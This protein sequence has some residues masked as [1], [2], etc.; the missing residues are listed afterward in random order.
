M[1]IRV[2]IV[3]DHEVVRRG[4]AA[5]LAANED[6]KVVGEASSAD[7]AVR[8]AG[9]DE[10]DVVVMDLLLPERSGIEGCRD[11]LAA[12]PKNPCPEAHVICRTRSP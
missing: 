5:L 3:D 11:I 8:R 12:F 7:E 9:M 4:L 2:L 1:P 6:I 10:P